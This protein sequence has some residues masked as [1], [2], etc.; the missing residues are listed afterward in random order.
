MAEKVLIVDDDVQSLRLVGLMLERQGYKIVAANNGVQGLRAAKSE[1]P[2][3]I[4]LDVMMP[5]MDGY[6]V[7]RRIRKTPETADIPI[8]MFTARTQVEDKITGYE[9]GVDDYLT[10]PIH[11]AELIA[12]LRAVLSRRRIRGGQQP[13]QD[14][15]HTI[16]VIAAKG[17]LGVSTLVLNLAIA[18]YQRTKRETIAAELRPGQGTWGF[19]LGFANPDGLANLL[20]LR[21]MDINS[22]TVEN[23]LV[24]LPY[25][26]RLL[27]APARSKD[28]EL[29]KSTE[30]IEVVVDALPYL[31]K[32]VIYDI[33]TPYI[34]GCEQI[35]N[36]CDE[37]ILVT[38]PF[39][40]TVHRTRALIEELGLRGFGKSKIMTV[41]SVNRV[42]ADMQISVLQMQEILR[43][44]IA[45]VIPPV[46][47]VAYQA[48]QRSI[49]ISQVQ[50]G[51]I[52][53]QQFVNLANM[54]IERVAV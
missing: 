2:D 8:L 50:P 27:L 5:D 7:T 35:L 47:E 19:E 30:Q 29:M 1:R 6:E 53:T 12:H 3:I 44:P 36:H 14:R 31:A 48:A 24:R 28:T 52:F 20:R 49:P 11:P 10:K 21:A 39:P 13:P 51:S 42:R 54:V 26:V 40:T 37:I 22:A 16:G 9:A 34:P 17:G 32:L 15:G 41:V 25:G 43:V 46:P 4:L 38:E 45:Q 23:E 33:G 18:F